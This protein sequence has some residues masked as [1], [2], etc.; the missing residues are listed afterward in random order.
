M[1]LP[2]KYLPVATQIPDCPG[3]IIRRAKS[4]TTYIY[5]QYGQRYNPEKRYA[6]P[7]RA[8][9]GKLTKDGLMLPNENY[10]KY[11]PGMNL[12][13]ERPRAFR[14]GCLRAGSH[15]LIRKLV[16]DYALPSLLGEF[17]RPADLGLF[18]DLAAYSLVSEDNAAQHYPDYAYNHPLFTEKMR[19]YSDSKVS[20]FL[21]SVTDDQSMGFLNAWNRRRIRGERIYISYDATSKN[22]QAG[23]LSMVEFGKAK[24]DSRLPVFNYSLGHDLT[25]KE[26][27]FYEECPGSI[28]DVPQLQYM[29]EKAH[30]YGY[31]DIGFILDRGCFSRGA[32][33]SLTRR[34]AASF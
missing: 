1:L 32:L 9:I 16:E 7:E 25:H 33:A 17:F 3:R 19:M 28:V 21:G 34:A 15:F 2:T 10:R 31:R 4:G 18:L 29:L 22:S 13:G 24:D 6:I 14:S 26:P 27:L 12:P 20:E 5:Y 30:G 8:C 23:D 11:F